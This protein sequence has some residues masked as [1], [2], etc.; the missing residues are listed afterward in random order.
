[1][2]IKEQLDQWINDSAYRRAIRQSSTYLKSLDEALQ[3]HIRIGYED[4]ANEM[5]ELLLI[6]VES[7]EEFLDDT[8]IDS[9]VLNDERMA[10]VQAN[11]YRKTIKDA[12][13]ALAEIQEK[14]KGDVI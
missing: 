5:K 12:Q 10:F 1:M 4:G 8:Q 6:A 11:V 3:W 7:L 2:N 9:L 14:I 13:K